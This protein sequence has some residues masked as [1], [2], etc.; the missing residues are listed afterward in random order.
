[1]QQ[2]VFIG[3]FP[4]GGTD[5]V[6]TILNSHPDIYINGEMQFLYQLEQ[7][8]FSSNVLMTPQEVERLRLFLHECNV[9]SS[10]ENINAPFLD[11]TAITLQEALYYLFSN[12][13]RSIWGNK[14]PQNTKHISEL[15]RIFPDAK[16]IIVVRDVRDVCLSW[17][18]KWG[19][20]MNWCANKWSQSM[21]NLQK[22]KQQLS[23]E[24]IF[25]LHFESL[26]DD[27]KNICQQLCAFLEIPFSSNMLEHHKHT[28][29]KWNGKL[30]YG[31]PILSQNKQKWRTAM[32]SECVKRIEEIAYERM[33]WL[34]Y[35]PTLATK[36]YPLTKA[37]YLVGKIRD[38]SALLFVGNRAKSNNS[39]TER[40][41]T[42]IKT[43]KKAQ[44]H[45]Q[46]KA[47]VRLTKK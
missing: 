23:A 46:Q 43:I 38:L 11:E 20:D 3:G 7:L 32:S 9:N 26:L 4:S 6:K 28:K 8:G 47:Y 41:Q 10:C 30:N 42:L 17:H 36:S 37:E 34:D 44:L 25:V 45:R 5:L 35:Q 19:K 14:T 27:S 40:W 24:Q 16:F 29:D 1:M 39:L 13:Q 21:E 2:M 31:Q 15:S 22:S 12:Q 33:K 18:N